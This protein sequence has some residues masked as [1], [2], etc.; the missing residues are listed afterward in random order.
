MPRDPTSLPK[1]SR[2]VTASSDFFS[3]SSSEVSRNAGSAS[4]SITIMP[5]SPSVAASEK[6]S[7][8]AQ[9]RQPATWKRSMKAEKR[10]KYSR[11]QRSVRKTVESSRE[12]KSSRKRLSF[13]LPSWPNRSRNE[14]LRPMPR[15]AHVMR[16][17]RAENRAGGSPR[18]RQPV[19]LFRSSPFRKRGKGRNGHRVKEGVSG[20]IGV[21]WGRYRSAHHRS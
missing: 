15:L 8:T 12:S 19:N 6:G 13:A 4:A 3:Q 10:S 16:Q 11:S 1:R 9:R 21:T 2:K 7:T 17:R 5:P 14:C 18:I 20:G